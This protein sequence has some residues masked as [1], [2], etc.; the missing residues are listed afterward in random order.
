MCEIQENLVA[1]CCWRDGV[2]RE[3]RKDGQEGAEEYFI[4]V[5]AGWEKYFLRETGLGGGPNFKTE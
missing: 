2:G 1:Y 3:K 5:V 4:I